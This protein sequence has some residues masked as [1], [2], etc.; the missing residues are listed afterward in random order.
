M[1]RSSEVLPLSQPLASLRFLSHLLHCLLQN[2][3]INSSALILICHC[4]I[5]P[6]EIQYSSLPSRVLELLDTYLL[7]HPPRISS[8][9]LDLWSKQSGTNLVICSSILTNNVFPVTL[10]RSLLTILPI[11]WTPKERWRCHQGSSF[12]M[13]PFVSTMISVLT[14][15]LSSF[16][17]STHK[18]ANWRKI[19]QTRFNFFSS[20]RFLD[21]HHFLRKRTTER[22]VSLISCVIDKSIWISPS[23]SCVAWYMR[24]CVTSIVYTTKCHDVVVSLP[25]SPLE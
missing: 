11:M 2:L 16:L 7:V 4:Q 9:L 18:I 25:M 1:I 17:Q 24:T 14:S 12:V 15:Y 21:E 10:S 20:S 6:N 8:L 23:T 5:F 3:Q 13:T 22:N 19:S